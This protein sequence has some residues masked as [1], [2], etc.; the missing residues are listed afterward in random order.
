MVTIAG[1][2]LSHCWYV[3]YVR[4]VVWLLSWQTW[5]KCANP[6]CAQLFYLPGEMASLIDVPCPDDVYALAIKIIF[7]GWMKLKREGKGLQENVKF[8][9]LL[10]KKGKKFSPIIRF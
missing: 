6:Y 2:I 4:N 1:N 8:N 10:L 3:I 7:I 9:K 5:R